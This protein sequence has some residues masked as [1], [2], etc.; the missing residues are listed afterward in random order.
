MFHYCLGRFGILLFRSIKLL[1][2]SF[3]ILFF[4]V[5]FFLRLTSLKNKLRD[6]ILVFNWLYFIFLFFKKISLWVISFFFF[7]FSK[8]SKRDQNISNAKKRKA[9]QS[10]NLK[11]DREKSHP[12]VINRYCEY[13]FINYIFFL[14]YYC[15]CYFSFLL[16]FT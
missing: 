2:L 3:F 10:R 8:F 11:E 7:F 14:F 15:F 5:K 13:V 1:L 4:L 16:L 12:D 9:L 6:S